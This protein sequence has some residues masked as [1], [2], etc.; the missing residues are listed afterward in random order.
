MV[1]ITNTVPH[2]TEEVLD[3]KDRAEIHRIIAD[4]RQ[5]YVE[6]HTE[7]LGEYH[8]AQRTANRALHEV[9]R[10]EKHLERIKD[11]CKKNNIPLEEG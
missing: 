6:R 1:L 9:N 4:L 2:H 8:Q 7:A 5:T 10:V 11:F 3:E